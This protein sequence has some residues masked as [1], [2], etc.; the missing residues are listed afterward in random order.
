[1]TTM[2]MGSG[3]L[4]SLCVLFKVY[5]LTPELAE[6]A[7]Q[8]IVLSFVLLIVGIIVWCWHLFTHKEVAKGQL[9]LAL[10]T[11]LAS[12]ALSQSLFAL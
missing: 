7:L 2:K 4:M 5:G 6:Q 3:I 11:L 1:M 9:V 10:L 12:T 8:G